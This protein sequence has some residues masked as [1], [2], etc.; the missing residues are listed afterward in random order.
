ME[1]LRKQIQRLAE[2]QYRKGFQQG[3]LAC[4]QNELTEKD[5]LE[6]RLEGMKNGY[7]KCV[8]PFNG[9]VIK[10]R[11]I[12]R[13]EMAM[14]EMVELKRFLIYKLSCDEMD[15]RVEFNENKQHFHL[16][17]S[18]NHTENTNGYVTIIDK[19]ADTQWRIFESFVNRTKRKKLT[20]EYVLNC[21]QEVEGFIN[22]LSE[23]GLTIEKR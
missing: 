14:S 2:K 22:N 7:S 10:S 1:K 23:Y 4:K 13:A 15:Y 19:A 12:L 18:R 16:S 9:R 11:D 6:F 21:V 5:V 17:Y 8:D 3:F 20:K